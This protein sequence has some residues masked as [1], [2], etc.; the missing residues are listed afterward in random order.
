MCM[1]AD[2]FVVCGVC[3]YIYIE[4]DSQQITMEGSTGWM[5]HGWMDFSSLG[6]YFFFVIPGY[7]MGRTLTCSLARVKIGACTYNVK[8][9]VPKSKRMFTFFFFFV[10]GRK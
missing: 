2:F 8:F 5:D 10:N 3:I 6:F 9:V 1:R 7:W 4:M